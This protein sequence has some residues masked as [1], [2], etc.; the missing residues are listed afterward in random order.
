MNAI[1]KINRA[2]D[3]TAEEIYEHISEL[4]QA[5]VIADRELLIEDILLYLRKEHLFE[6]DYTK[7]N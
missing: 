1:E 3:Q 7:R 2:K 5:E 4:Y 6:S